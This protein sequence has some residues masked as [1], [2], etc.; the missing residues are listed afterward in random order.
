MRIKSEGLTF[1]DVLIVPQR[2]SVS[3]R[4]NISTESRVIGDIH[5]DIPIVSSPMDTVTD[6]HMAD[7][8]EAAGGIGILHRFAPFDERLRMVSSAPDVTFGAAI[9]INEEQDVPER[10]LDAGADFVCVD[11]AHAH[12]DDAISTVENI[13]GL[14]MA[15][16]IA[17][18]EAAEDLIEAGADSLRVGVGSGSACTTRVNT[19][20]GVPQMTALSDVAEVARG[21]DVTVIADGGIRTPG[22]ASKALLVGADAVIMGGE[23][24]V[25]E[26][27]AAP[28]T[29]HG[30]KL[31]RG[32]ASESARIDMYGDSSMVEGE[33]FKRPLNGS[34][35]SLLLRYQDGVR[36]AISYCGADN[37]YD[38]KDNAV[39]TRITDNTVWRNGAHG[40]R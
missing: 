37:I 30:E 32:M 17:T 33:T 38:A 26:E 34:V 21:E 7:A 14:V 8:M 10:L 1:D 28:V 5:V 16:T 4:H 29:P 20:V 25:C 12:H 11:V 35:K 13:D 22:D 24:A 6:M 15:G 27:S 36:S 40:D 23:L 39:F 2:S 9:G 18:A 31:F 19:G 3:S